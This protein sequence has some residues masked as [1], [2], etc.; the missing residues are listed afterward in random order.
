MST[1]MPDNNMV[2]NNKCKIY[3]EENYFFPDGYLNE[4]EDLIN[5]NNNNY[6][7]LEFP[8]SQTQSQNQGQSQGQ[9]IWSDLDLAKNLQETIMSVQKEINSLEKRDKEYDFDFLFGED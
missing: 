9:D 8:N 7:S 5:N 3:H 2:N 6:P 1:Q 4:E